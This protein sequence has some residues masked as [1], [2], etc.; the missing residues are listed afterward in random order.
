MNILVKILQFLG[1]SNITVDSD[2]FV[3]YAG[4]VLLLSVLAILGFFSMFLSFL[5]IMLGY[6]QK[7]LNYLS[8]WISSKWLNRLVVLSRVGNVYS[9]FI[10]LCIFSYI[11]YTLIWS[12][13]V[14]LSSVSVT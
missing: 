8:K 4:S 2:P 5:L 14:I 1:F 7:L 13:Y 6:N 10:E 3:L 9:I 11:M 12:S